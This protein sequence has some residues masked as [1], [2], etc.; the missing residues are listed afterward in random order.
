MV[1]RRALEFRAPL[2]RNSDGRWCRRAAALAVSRRQRIP[3]RHR[4]AKAMV[5][6]G[7]DV[8]V[9][10]TVVYAPL[11]GLTVVTALLYVL[12]MRGYTRPSYG[13]LPD[14]PKPAARP[15][16][17]LVPGEQHHPTQPTRF[18]TPTW[19]TIPAVACT[20]AS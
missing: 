11:I 13:P 3:G 17:F 5:V 15:E 14:Y 9:R 2:N 7:V 12:V 10:D 19:L 1:V 6:R 16:T 18:S 8:S 20:R 4:R